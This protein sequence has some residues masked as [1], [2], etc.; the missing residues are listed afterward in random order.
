ML[1]WD[2]PIIQVID[3]ISTQNFKSAWERKENRLTT[4]EATYYE[5]KEETVWLL[6]ALPGLNTPGRP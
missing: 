1:W 6:H 4:F 5:K 3:I 2:V